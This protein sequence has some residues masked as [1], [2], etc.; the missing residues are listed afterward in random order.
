MRPFNSQRLTAVGALAWPDG[1]T[2]TVEN[3]FAAAR[4]GH[5]ASKHT[6]LWV[7]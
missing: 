6:E 2:I 4:G 7:R 5:N 1:K 3:D